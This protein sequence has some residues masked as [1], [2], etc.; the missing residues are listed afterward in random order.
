MAGEAGEEGGE[1][2]WLEVR[3]KEAEQIPRCFGSE[4]GEVG[5]AMAPFGVGECLL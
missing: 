1:K 5:C 2:V 3:R 4:V